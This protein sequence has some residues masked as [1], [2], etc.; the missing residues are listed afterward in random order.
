MWVAGRHLLALAVA[1]H[2]I[3]HGKSALFYSL[4]ELLDKIRKEVINGSR[5]T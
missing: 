4:P 5:P 2:G 1:L 3:R